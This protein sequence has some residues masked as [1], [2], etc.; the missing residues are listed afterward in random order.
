MTL[1]AYFLLY[2]PQARVDSFC[3]NQFFSPKSEAVIELCEED[4]W[5]KSYPD[6]YDYE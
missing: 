2:I 4:V 3:E 5:K 6:A 1:Y